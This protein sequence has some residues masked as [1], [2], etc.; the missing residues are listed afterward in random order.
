LFCHIQQSHLE[1]KKFLEKAQ[2]KTD[3]HG[4]KHL[5]HDFFAVKIYPFIAQRNI[6]LQLYQN[7]TPYWSSKMLISSLSGLSPSKEYNVNRT[8]N[9]HKILFTSL[10]AC[11]SISPIANA[12]DRDHHWNHR[13][14]Y[15]QQIVRHHS[16]VYYPAQ[17]VYFSPAQNNW[18]WASRSGW[19][20]GTRLP[21]YLN[22]DLRFGGI[23][24]ALRSARP[25][26]EHPYVET[27]YGRSWRE[28]H[29]DGDYR[30]GG[31]HQNHWSENEFRHGES[32]DYGQRRHHGRDER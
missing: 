16:Y 19:Q 5:S 18:F 26:S 11:A 23:P 29:R 12:R 24:I 17:Q 6:L 9:I 21:S 1:N 3:T 15:Q 25:Y 2:C 7:V 13:P 20:I 8:S 31:R 14:I 27:R 10:I 22:V 28:S 30:N 4:S 32:R